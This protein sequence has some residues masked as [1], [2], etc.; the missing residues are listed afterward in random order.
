MT[1]RQYVAYYRVSTER[2][3]FSGLGLEAQRAAVRRFL[4]KAPGK[5]VAEFTEIK[6][7]SKGCRPQLAEAL[8]VCRMRR[9]VLLIASLDRLA[10]NVAL[11]SSLMDSDLEFV[12]VDFPRATRLT[13]HVLAAIAEYESSLISE[14][15]KAAFA[16][17][18]ARGV[19]LG[20]SRGKSSDMR[21][22]VAASVAARRAK[23]KARAMDLAPI[24]WDLKA[25]G[26]S[27]VE[28]AEHFNRQRIETPKR[29]KWRSSGVRRILRLTANE[30]R[31][32]AQA[33][34]TFPHPESL[35]AQARA[36]MLAPLVW[37]LNRRGMSPTSI[38]EE[39]NRRQIATPRKAKWRNST[40]LNILR[41]TA[42]SHGSIAEATDVASPGRRSMHAKQR[43]F[44]L[45][46]LLWKLRRRGKSVAAMADELARRNFRAP[47]GGSW[48]PS[49]VR[50]ILLLT[51]PAF[52][53]DDDIVTAVRLGR[54]PDEKKRRAISVAPVVWQ[55]RAEGKAV[56]V[57]AD[58]LNRRKIATPH[59]RPWRFNSI[60][61]VLKLT[62]SEFSSIGEAAAERSNVHA[63]RMRRA[64]ELGQVVWKLKKT[65]ISITEIAVQMT[66]NGIA[67]PQGKRTWTVKTVGKILRS[68]AAEFGPVGGE[69]ILSSRRV[70]ADRRAKELAPVFWELK[71]AGRTNLEIAGELDRRRIP[72]P[73][74]GRWQS[75]AV[76]RILALS[77]NGF[78]GFAE[79]AAA[80][81]H[82]HSIRARRRAQEIAPIAWKLRSSG[83]TLASVA[84]ELNRQNLTTPR[85]GK[86]CVAR[87]SR[88]LQ[89]T[90]DAFGP[91][92]KA[93]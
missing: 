87:V 73:K 33:A 21:A 13:L 56:A 53:P 64:L 80:R 85:K 57:I 25:K 63:I 77:A 70:R 55:L 4:E 31:S 18:K 35:R 90:A 61:N 93:A 92:Q 86:W 46:P 10:R 29:V 14:R 83:K 49:A 45:A 69:K 84:D 82:H 26:R 91:T 12:A 62:A 34:K 8:R 27:N 37:E 42:A 79:A 7:G 43:A 15:L 22:A 68:T 44:D 28:I 20:G 58:E 51:A 39:L 24:A 81:P 32:F 75:S 16:A 76:Q 19:K 52:A 30:F 78:V 67:A 89:A 5:L 66:R 23:T 3:G 65:G 59:G 60:R 74:G 41:R 11:I 17:A 47:C 40:V 6:S 54:H 1:A 38:G 71:A 2:Q 50:R 48:H 72:T 9:A 88:L 36:E